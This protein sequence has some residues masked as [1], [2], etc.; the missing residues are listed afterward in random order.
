MCLTNAAAA[1]RL[2]FLDY[3]TLRADRTRFEGPD[4]SWTAAASSMTGTA[5][6]TPPRPIGRS[7]SYAADGPVTAQP[8][9][10]RIST[11]ICWLT[12]T[13]QKST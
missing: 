10:G 5:G 7:G 9:L 8:G 3:P 1:T 12:G 4:D 6:V 13:S 11:K 2:S